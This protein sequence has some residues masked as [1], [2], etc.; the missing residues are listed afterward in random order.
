MPIEHKLAERSR[1]CKSAARRRSWRSVKRTLGVISAALVLAWTAIATAATS[2]TCHT[3]VIGPAN[4]T[5]YPR[6]QLPARGVASGASCSTLR[7]IARR[8]NSG[9][10]PIPLDAGAKGH[11]G[12]P[13]A[14]HDRGKRWSCRF[15]AIGGSG[16]TYAIRCASG[17]ARL[18]WRT[19]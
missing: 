6:H 14:V 19:G 15:E 12:R 16:P 17:A 1:G 7:R 4:S 9:T 13:F 10:Y 3:F 18:S 2:H 8:L 11:Y 5:A